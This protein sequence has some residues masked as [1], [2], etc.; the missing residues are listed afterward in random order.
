[1]EN[2]YKDHS[3]HFLA[4]DCIIF[5]YEKQTLKLLLYRRDFEPA[6]GSWSLIGGFVKSDESCEVAA[7][8][9]LQ[10]TTGLE[11]IYL[12]QVAVFSNPQREEVA[13]V[14]TVAFVALVN[15][16]DKKP[17]TDL[18]GDTLWWPMTHLPKMVFDHAAMVDLALRQ[19][20]HKA[21]YSLVGA[22]LLPAIFTMKQLRSLYDAIYQRKFDAGNFRKKILSL[23]LLERLDQKDFTG[24][25]KGSFYYK[26][27]PESMDAEIDRIVKF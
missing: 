21:G 23:H 22:E 11:N 7:G 18:V 2:F 19:L 3:L 27:K 6:R 14:V 10:K 25:K 15:I 8:R 1:M 5:G 24:S 12:D 13:R 4:V 9:I 26:L 17:A 20:Q 16:H